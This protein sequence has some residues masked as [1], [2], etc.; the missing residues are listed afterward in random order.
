MPSSSVTYPVT[1]GDPGQDGKTED[2]AESAPSP[3][4]TQPVANNDS[5]LAQRASRLSATPEEMFTALV[6]EM[7][8]AQHVGHIEA[9]S[10]SV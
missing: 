3:S 1:N 8:E 2:K 7:K 5:G 9:W 6:E 10:T 4:V